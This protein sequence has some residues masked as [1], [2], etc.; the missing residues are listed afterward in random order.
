MHE[1]QA[2][3]LISSCTNR[4]KDH[5]RLVNIKPRGEK[6]TY[7]PWNCV[8]SIIKVSLSSNVGSGCAGKMGEKNWDCYIHINSQEKRVPVN[9]MFYEQCSIF[10][11][12]LDI[13]S[14]IKA[15]HGRQNIHLSLALRKR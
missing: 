3:A 15:I 14:L 4:E 11:L 6:E 5:S 1:Q 2:N 7:Q 9:S 8:N 12:A 10:S 13:I